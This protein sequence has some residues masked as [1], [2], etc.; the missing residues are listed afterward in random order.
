[1]RF[2]AW[3]QRSRR[4]AFGTL[5]LT[6]FFSEGKA[7][8]KQQCCQGNSRSFHRSASLIFYCAFQLLPRGAVVATGFVL[9]LI[10][11]ETH[12]AFNRSPE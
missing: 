7:K 4:G 12:F 9:A 2:F 8:D 5:L 11:V 6:G 10:A 1:L 3:G